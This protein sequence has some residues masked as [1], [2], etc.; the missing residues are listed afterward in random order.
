[1]AAHRDSGLVIFDCDGVLVDS[2]LLAARG[3]SAVLGEVG[4]EIPA[5]VMEG[6]IGLKQADIFARIEAAVG[7][8]I[9]A[10]VAERLWLRTREIFEAELES[11]AGLRDFLDRLTFPACVASSS[12][13]ERIRLSLRLT[14]LERYFGDAVFSTHMV[15]RGKPAPDIFLYAARQMGVDPARCVVI[16]DSGPGVRGAV[17]AGMRAIGFLGGAHIRDGHS[18]M[19]REAGADFLAA[20]WTD[21]DRLLASQDLL[22]L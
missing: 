3:Y 13:L 6:A 4:L 19:L 8:P 15:A 16:E 20:S 11:T 7:R 22:A 2:E 1:L 14:G 10:E 17:A 12:H 18:E 9:P 5:G 21:V